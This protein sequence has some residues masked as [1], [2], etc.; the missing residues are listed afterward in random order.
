MI[1]GNKE[2]DRFISPIG[3]N[4]DG[5]P[6]KEEDIPWK[7]DENGMIV[8]KKGMSNTDDADSS[9]RKDNSPKK[10]KQ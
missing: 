6:W 8:M 7:F 9:V 1:Q 5:E 10:T 2:G 4:D 3:L